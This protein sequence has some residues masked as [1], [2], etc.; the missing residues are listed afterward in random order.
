[1]S[2]PATETIR[3]RLLLAS[4]SP[5]RR[6]LLE[7]AGLE[8]SAEAAP[9]DEEEAKLALEGE[10]ADGPA[11]AEALAELKAVAVARRHPGAFV[12][13]ADQVLDCEGRRYDKPRD[14]AAARA[15]LMALRGRTHQLISAL[16]VVRDGRRLWHHIDRATLTMR[17]FSPAFLDEYLARSMPGIL[18][19]VG[20]YQ[21][22]ARGAQLFSRIEGDYFTILGLPLLPL[23]DFLR[24]HGLVPA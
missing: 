21:L 16:V 5:T 12:I 4:A 13:G 14:E 15:Q 7:Q 20:A 24:P 23:L 22:E 2:A 8:F 11:L 18:S 6:R 17:P 1:M 3:P 9:I 10:G 19:S